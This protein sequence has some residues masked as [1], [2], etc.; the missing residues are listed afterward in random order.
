MKL[1]TFAENINKLAEKYPDLEVIYSSDDEGNYFDIVKFEPTLGE[2]NDREF[3]CYHELD[4]EEIKINA[5]C[6]N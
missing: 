4:Q 5:I 3:Y 6:I 1:K 2:Y